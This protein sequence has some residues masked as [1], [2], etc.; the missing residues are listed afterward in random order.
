MHVIDSDPLSASANGWLEDT[1]KVE[2]YVMTDEDY[3]KRENTYR[4]ATVGAT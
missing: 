1:S 2:K 4:Y 3:A